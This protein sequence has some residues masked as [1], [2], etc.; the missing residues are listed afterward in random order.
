MTRWPFP[1]DSPL[2]KARR[3][4]AAYREV[5]RSAGADVAALD[6]HF[7][8]LGESWVGGVEHTGDDDV[9]TAAEAEDRLGIPASR[10]WQWKARGML[11]PV[12]DSPT[13]YRVHDVRELEAAMRRKRAT[14]HR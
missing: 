2:D 10:V 14:R 8:R 3:M 9:V 13:R 1:A 11:D 7:A 12:A 6:A 4:C 5:A